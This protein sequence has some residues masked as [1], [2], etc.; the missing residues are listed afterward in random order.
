MNSSNESEEAS[1]IGREPKINHRA[2]QTFRVTSSAINRIHNLACRGKKSNPAQ[3]QYMKNMVVRCSTLGVF[4]LH[5]KN[6]LK[7]AGIPVF[8]K[9]LN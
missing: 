7:H 3:E 4:P 2:N 5:Q 8:V 6:F 9:P 1:R